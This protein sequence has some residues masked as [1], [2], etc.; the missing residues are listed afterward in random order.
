METSD[1]VA[2]LPSSVFEVSQAS[3]SLE[4]ELLT[5]KVSFQYRE[6]DRI[7]R[8]PGTRNL[9]IIRLPIGR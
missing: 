5:T 2:A 1:R 8:P 3:L 4:G 6:R 7:V 9:L